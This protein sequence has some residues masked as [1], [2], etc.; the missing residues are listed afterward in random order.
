[1]SNE[2]VQIRQRNELQPAANVTSLPTAL[3]LMA[4]LKQ[5]IVG[6]QADDVLIEMTSHTEGHRASSRFSFRAYRKGRQVA[7]GEHDV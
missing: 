1:M 2:I 3:E 5:A 4:G 6:M 7:G